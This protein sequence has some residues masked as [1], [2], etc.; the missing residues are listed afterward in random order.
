MIQSMAFPLETHR[1]SV[2]CKIKSQMAHLGS[3]HAGVSIFFGLSHT[4]MESA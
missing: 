1:N 3:I 2:E 4:D